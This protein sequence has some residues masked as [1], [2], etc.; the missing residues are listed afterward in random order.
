VA[1]LVD[2][3]KDNCHRAITKPFKKGTVAEKEEKDQDDEVVAEDPDEELDMDPEG[4]GKKGFVGRKVGTLVGS[5]SGT[6]VNPYC[7]PP[8]CGVRLSD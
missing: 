6:Q 8:L 2:N 3:G 5:F 7:V 4:D 1:L